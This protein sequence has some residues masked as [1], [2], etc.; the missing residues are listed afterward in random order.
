MRPDVW[1]LLVAFIRLAGGLTE[2]PALHHGVHKGRN[3]TAGEVQL[4]GN[5]AVAQVQ[6]SG[7]VAAQLQLLETSQAP[8]AAGRPAGAD[9][10]PRCPGGPQ[11]PPW[12]GFEAGSSGRAEWA[13]GARTVPGQLSGARRPA[14]PPRLALALLSLGAGSLSVADP[15]RLRLEVALGVLQLTCHGF[16][17]SLW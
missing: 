15:G 13:S 16:V 10:V 8:D 4:F 2:V 5:A 7:G 17:Q 12:A 9:S 1:E 11:R 14:S 6:F 3:V